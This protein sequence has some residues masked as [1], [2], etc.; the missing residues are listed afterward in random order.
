MN[1]FRKILLISAIFF[2]LFST[3]FAFANSAC[4]LMQGS[5]GDSSVCDKSSINLKT[6]ARNIINTLLW[7]VGVAAVIM[8]IYGGIQYVISAGDSGKVGKAKNTILYAVIGLVV[9]VMSY[10][11]V[12]FVVSNL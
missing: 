2:S 10:A 6:T 9:A 1:T 7:V 4:D 12:N 11:I 5:A 8:I 3:N